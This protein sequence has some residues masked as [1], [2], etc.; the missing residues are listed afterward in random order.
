MVHAQKQYDIALTVGVFDVW[1]RGHQ[2]LADMMQKTA[3]L[4]IALVHDDESTFQ[5]KGHV[6]MQGLAER[7]KNASKYG[8]FLTYGVEYDDPSY[9][10]ER[11][12]E[13]L[14]K[15]VRICFMRGDD[16]QDFPGR[17]M[18]ESLGVDI[19]FKRYTEGVS[20]TEI[21]RGGKKKL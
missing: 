12:V 13:H 9:A 11:M 7:M 21:L 14:P 2:E 10:I 20:S 1:H 6:P 4:C 17:K 3:P 8:G 16:W 19:L 5:N 15:E 18:V